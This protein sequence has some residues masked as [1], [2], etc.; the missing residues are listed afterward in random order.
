MQQSIELLIYIG[1]ELIIIAI[2][3]KFKNIVP[4][5]NFIGSIGSI[6]YII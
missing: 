4:F 5:I 2:I 3:Y 1:I 6:Y